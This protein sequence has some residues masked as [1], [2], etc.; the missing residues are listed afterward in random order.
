MRFC[1]SASSVFGT[2]A[3]VLKNQSVTNP[4]YKLKNDTVSDNLIIEFL[5]IMIP[6]RVIGET[7][8]IIIF[9]VWEIDRSRI[10][11]LLFLAISK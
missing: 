4:D 9:I 11:I 2:N 5:V 10:V 6:N 8:I 3:L 1:L 7:T